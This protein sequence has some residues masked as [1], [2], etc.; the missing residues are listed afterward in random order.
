MGSTPVNLTDTSATRLTGIITVSILQDLCKGLQVNDL[1]SA[2]TKLK[3]RA[4]FKAERS[5]WLVVGMSF[6]PMNIVFVV[7]VLVWCIVTSARLSK[8][9]VWRPRNI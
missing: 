9:I 4:R 2:H 6:V 5:V 3:I 8:L 7:I 1:G